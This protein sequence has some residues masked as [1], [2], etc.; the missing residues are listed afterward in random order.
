MNR[1]VITSISQFADLS[2][3]HPGIL[4]INTFA[5]LKDIITTVL[6]KPGCKCNIGKDLIV[7]RPQFE[8]AMAM[9]SPQDQTRMKALLNAETLCYYHKEANGKL[10]QVCF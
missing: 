3:R 10:S 4:N 6:A 2:K 9:L 7:Y 1:V 5:G 8:A